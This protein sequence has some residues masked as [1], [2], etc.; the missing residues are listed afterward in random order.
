M[1]R[2]LA[3]VRWRPPLDV[4]AVILAYWLMYVKAPS[5]REP[6][7]DG[8]YELEANDVGALIYEDHSG[9]HF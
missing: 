4:D 1:D 6:D 3:I 7:S 8:C 5:R 2:C 9:V